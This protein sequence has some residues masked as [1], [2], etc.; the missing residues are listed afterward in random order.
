MGG[1][2]ER[3]DVDRPACLCDRLHNIPCDVIVRREGHLDMIVTHSD[4][5][6]RQLYRMTRPTLAGKEQ[7]KLPREI[8]GNL[9]A[10]ETKHI[11]I[12]AKRVVER[13][14]PRAGPRHRTIEDDKLVVHKGW[15]PVK[16]DWDTGL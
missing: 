2:C 12:V 10:G 4:H 7:L 15:T 6:L 8:I 1:E 3:Q 9:R 16:G 11:V 14:V 13:Q 5:R